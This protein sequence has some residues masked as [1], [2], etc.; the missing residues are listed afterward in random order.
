MQRR[1]FIQTS[2]AVAGLSMSLSPMAW[3]AASKGKVVII[4]GGYAGATAA[5]YIR[6][7]SGGQ[8]Q[9]TLIEPNATFI[10]C[11]MSNLVVGGIKTIDEISTP[12]TNLEKKH[13][14]KI[15]QTTVK[16]I[17][18]DKQSVTLADGSKLPYDKL[19][20]S[21]GIDLMLDKIEGLAKEN[22]NGNTVQA[23]K[24]GPE[25]LT[26]RK[27][28]EAMKDGGTYVITVPKAPYRCP[29]GPYE[30]ASMVANYFKQS[31]PNSK[32]LILDANEKI[33]SKGKLFSAAWKA[34]YGDMVEHRPSHNVMAV[35]GKTL[36][37]EFEEPITADVLNVLPEM[38]GGKIAVDSGIANLNNRWAEVDYMTFESKIASNV[39][40]IG[41]TI[42]VAPKMPKSG[43]MANSQAKVAAAA[44]VS[45]LFG[46]EPNAN[47]VTNNTCYSFVNST[48]VI[49]VASVHQ[50]NAEKK[51]FLPVEGAGGLSPEPSELEGKYAWSWAQNIWAD[52]LV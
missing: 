24:A 43:H 4:G 1:Q 30:R 46:Y 20:L 16:T 45:S 13:G 35:K 33:M 17:D 8:V 27:Q 22:A 25:T 49:H 44:I 52:T 15:L 47:P 14:V 39:H 9:V 26:L 50:Y 21:P 31:K 23:W 19:V 18:S 51:T 5:K 48:D 10:S 32:V 36:N 34:N 29:P 41:D 3:A 38:R 12:Y 40:V 42:Q 28:L 6:M 7:L 2:A 11:P 37:F